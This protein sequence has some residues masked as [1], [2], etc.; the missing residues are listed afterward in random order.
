M[1]ET[2]PVS[3]LALG[4]R[5]IDGPPAMSE[6]AGGA[7]F[8]LRARPDEAGLAAALG[9]ALK[10]ALPTEPNTESR[11]DGRHALWLGPDEWLARA[12]ESDRESLLSALEAASGGRGAV[13]DV[14]DNF[15]IVR[16]SG[17]GAREALAAGCPLDLHPLKFAPGRCAQSHV[18]HASALIDMPDAAPTFD[19]QVRRSYAAYLWDYLRAASAA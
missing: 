16:I 7:S 18:G 10:C 12:P 14:S 1:A 17:E 3:R 8:V 19:V 11:A 4:G 15:S 9:E 6:I 5:R 13:V 2:A